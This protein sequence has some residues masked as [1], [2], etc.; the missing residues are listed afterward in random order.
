MWHSGSM[1]VTPAVLF[2]EIVLSADRLIQAASI[3]QPAPDQW[4]PHVVLGHIALN[5]ERNWLVRIES[6]T[7]AHR[8]SQPEPFFDWFEPEAAEVEERFKD[9]TIDEA[10]AELLSTRTQIVLALRELSEN[11]WQATAQH[12]I[13]GTLTVTDLV[14][15]MLAHDEEHRAGLLLGG[16]ITGTLET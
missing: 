8:Q 7:S 6:M 16:E 4:P 2:A 1:A 15:R 11:D 5:D 14:L 9:L 12:S 10:G 3:S 13:F